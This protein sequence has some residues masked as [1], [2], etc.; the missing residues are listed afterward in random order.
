MTVELIEIAKNYVKEKLENE[1]SGHD[2]LHTLRVFNMATRIAK[3]EGANLEIVQLS[4]LLHDVDDRK[5]SP[6]TYEN[7]ANARGLLA[8]NGVEITC[9]TVFYTKNIEYICHLWY[10]FVK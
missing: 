10:N 7:Q 6:E 8:T 1:F 4:A 5:I 3:S 9:F 2:Y